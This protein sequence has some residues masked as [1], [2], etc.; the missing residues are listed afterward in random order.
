MAR[1]SVSQAKR[2][3]QMR[4][5]TFVLSSCVVLMCLG[6]LTARLLAAPDRSAFF[7][8]FWP[9]VSR[10]HTRVALSSKVDENAA[11]I[12]VEE[13]QRVKKGERLIEFDARIIKARIAVAEAEADF[14]ARMR[15]A[16]T[17]HKYLSK[18]HDRCCKLEKGRGITEF[19][20]DEARYRMEMAGHDV[21]DLK[22]Q[23]KLAERNLHY[24]VTR[25]D[26]YVVKSPIDGVVSHVWIKEAEMAKQGE[27]LLEVIAP[28][29]IEVRI[30]VAEE[31]AGNVWAKQK[32]EVAFQAVSEKSFIG[33]VRS[34]SPYVDSKSGKFMVKVL[35]EPKDKAI[36]PGM[37]CRVKFLK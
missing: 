30:H 6:G 15:S 2:D 37:G 17:K 34:V 18:Q 5:K 3:T 22:R 35:V 29:V 21:E 26:D 11:T 12:M 19:E 20:I 13:G 33:A 31:N 24:F 28:D 4:A 7:D 9:A 14:A 27:A 23:R 36:K 8:R 25:A 16:Q 32:V 1:D 10:P